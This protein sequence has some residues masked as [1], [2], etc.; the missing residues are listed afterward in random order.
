MTSTS[1]PAP[2]GIE[3]RTG[4]LVAALARGDF[5]AAV[6][7]FGDLMKSALPPEKLGATW[8]GLQEQVGAL[9]GVESIELQSKDGHTAAIATARFERADLLIRVGFDAGGQIVG[10]FFAP[11]PP[12][13]DWT[14]PAYVEVAAFEERPVQ[15][16]S[17]PA[18]PGVLSMPNGAGPF[19][20]VVLVH[21]SGPND[22]DGT[23]G[24]V[25]VFKD[26]AAGLAS[27]A[28]AV[29]R[30]VKRSRH[31]PAGIVTQKE[32]VED[33][34]RDA[35]LL[36][37]ATPGV[38]PARVFVLGHSQGG[39]L[40][41]RIAAANPGLAG[42]VVLAGS[43]RPLQDSMLEQLTYFTRLD[44]ENPALSAMLEATRRFKAAVEAPALS[45]EQTV[46]LPTGG[47]VT[48]AYF[49][50]VRGY[51]PPDVAAALPVRMLV[52]QGERDYQVTLT[53]LQGWRDALS[54][55]SDVVFKTYPSLN[56]LFVAGEGTP[57]PAEYQLPGHVDPQVVSDI[58]AWIAGE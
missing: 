52:L 32:E 55:R 58:A 50:D 51:H 12:V 3:S 14:P 7:D 36:L 43:T 1:A 41:P 28:I 31:S 11:K 53:D 27:R 21:G 45:P 47:S 19:P 30:Y 33:A 29:L 15:V 2:E 38:D 24:H 4:H 20:A 18:L 22:E 57:T 44:P 13:V 48:G 37:R 34:A 6:R 23:V 26:L 17:R 49:L 42:L 16:G 39:Y 25:K 40:A 56:H 5:H 10:L 9:R 54:S 35:L 8:Q 46:D